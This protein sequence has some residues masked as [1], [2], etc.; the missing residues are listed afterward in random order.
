[1]IRPPPRSTLFPYT[2]LFRSRRT[3]AAPLVRELSHRLNRSTWMSTQTTAYAL[4]AVSAYVG[5][6]T[7]ASRNSR[8]NYRINQAAAGKITFEKALL[9]ERLELEKEPEIGRAH[10]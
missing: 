4:L 9:Q 7:T 2:T 8:F 5:E 6:G 1:M 10:V 3:E